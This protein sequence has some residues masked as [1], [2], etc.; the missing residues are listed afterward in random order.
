MKSLDERHIQ[1]STQKIKMFQHSPRSPSIITR[2][3]YINI[4]KILQ[5]LYC[6]HI[7]SS[8]SDW[9]RPP[10]VLKHLNFACTVSFRNHLVFSGK[11]YLLSLLFCASLTSGRTLH[12]G[13]SVIDNHM[14]YIQERS[15]NL[16]LML[17]WTMWEKYETSLYICRKNLC[18]KLHFIQFVNNS[19]SEKRIICNLQKIKRNIKY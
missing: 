7:H 8:F 3:M 18:F 15:S 14:E 1:R 5:H 11:N 10:R 2:W 13:N 4:Q 6:V 19:S 16:D 12:L 17:G 9:Q